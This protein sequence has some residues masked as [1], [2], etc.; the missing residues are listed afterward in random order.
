MTAAARTSLSRHATLSRL[1]LQP[2]HA[3]GPH[4]A[5]ASSN[6]GRRPMLSPPLRRLQHPLLR[7]ERN[8]A[9]AKHSLC[10][11]AAAIATV[12]ARTL[13]RQH[14]NKTLATTCHC[15][16]IA[17]RLHRLPPCLPSLPHRD[18]RHVAAVVMLA[19]RFLRCGGCDST[20]I[21]ERLLGPMPASRTSKSGRPISRTMMTAAGR[22]PG[23]LGTRGWGHVAPEGRS[24]ST[25]WQKRCVSAS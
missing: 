20:R 14:H 10:R 16:R 19:M 8:S 21:S 18:R 23:S 3:V 13:H 24:S 17:P 7:T 5:T 25:N 22:E 15:R 12:T 9:C 6:G 11:A 1:H 2:T 4:N